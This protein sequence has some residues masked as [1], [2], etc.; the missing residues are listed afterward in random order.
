MS[1]RPA[2]LLAL[3]LL[4]ACGPSRSA[5]PAA[6]LSAGPPS[7][8]P[9]LAALLLQSGD[10][11]DQ[12][13]RRESTSAAAT[14]QE[15]PQLALCREP[16]PVGPHQLASVLAKARAMGQAQVF[17]IVSV[18]ADAPAAHAAFTRALSAARACPSYIG[19]GV[20]FT[21]ADLA[22][23][24]VAGADEA[25]HYRLTTP[26]VIDGD[27]RTLARRGRYLVLLTGYGAPPAGQTLL[28]FQAAV[29]T[30]A[31]RRLG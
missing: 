30:K 6:P 1:R 2:A 18:F 14:S 24:A 9:A 8:V 28:G 5:A 22:Q 13:L 20:R 19:Q 31:V 11:P 21:V 25:L 12:P 4:A 17:E 7:P 15:T 27:V 10:L 3:L 23:P 16:A 29:M 26:S